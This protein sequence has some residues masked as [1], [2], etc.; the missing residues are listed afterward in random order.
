MSQVATVQGF[1][2]QAISDTFSADVESCG[3]D[4]ADIVTESSGCLD[5]VVL[6]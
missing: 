6:I 1:M 4:L 3:R 2:R 5:Q